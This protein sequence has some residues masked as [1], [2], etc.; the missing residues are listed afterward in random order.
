MLL[1]AYD[2]NLVA[3]ASLV[4]GRVPVM[5]EL[6][7]ESR[8]RDSLFFFC[9]FVLPVSPWR[10]WNLLNV[11]MKDRITGLGIGRVRVSP[12]QDIIPSDR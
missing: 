6:A 7:K 3:S 2:D 12:I 1:A 9:I 11:R 8:L 4:E 10:F 5:N